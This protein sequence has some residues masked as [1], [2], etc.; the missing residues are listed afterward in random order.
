MSINKGAEFFTKERHKQE[1]DHYLIGQKV[2]PIKSLS[3]K[4]LDA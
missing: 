2:L 4:C 3:L 1:K